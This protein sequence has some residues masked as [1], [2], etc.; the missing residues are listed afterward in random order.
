MKT[1]TH[2]Q[3]ENPDGITAIINLRTF[4]RKL[5]IDIAKYQVDDFSSEVIS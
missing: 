2:C 5:S 4:Q 1:I 3:T